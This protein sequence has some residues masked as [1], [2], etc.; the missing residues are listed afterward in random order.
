MRRLRLTAGWV[1]RAICIAAGEVM[2]IS[3]FTLGGL[4]YQ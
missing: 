3:E 4:G 2:V 1:E